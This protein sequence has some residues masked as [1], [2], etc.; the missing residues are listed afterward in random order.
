M[1]WIWQ[2]S[3]WPEFRWD[4]ALLQALLAKIH[5]K[6]GELIG[7][8]NV[9]GIRVGLETALSAMS[10]ELLRSSEIEGILLNPD[11]VRSSVAVR[12]GLAHEGLPAPNTVI[13][14]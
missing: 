2:D 10:E 6:Q 1:Q 5:Q 4:S 9:L 7:M 14:T 11:Q 3:Q 8:L 12:L 13:W